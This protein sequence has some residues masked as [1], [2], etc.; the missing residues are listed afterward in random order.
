MLGGCS[1]R[2]SHYTIPNVSNTHSL[3]VSFTRDAQFILRFE[4]KMFLRRI[5]VANRGEIAVRLL[6]TC[7]K[8][9]IE[10]I[11]IYVEEDA[12]ALHVREANE[13]YLLEGSVTRGYLDAAS[14]IRI[15]KERDVQ[16]VLPGYGFL[17]ENAEFA[18]DLQD[19]GI[20]FVGPA[21][22]TLREFGLKDC[23][24]ELAIKVGVP[25]V[26]GTAIIQDVDEA[27]KEAI[28]L[29]FPVS[30]GPNRALS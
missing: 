12:T 22:K 30:F 26:P 8:L 15:C 27:K 7:K 5:L 14:I 10:S 19:A 29:C 23:A 20:H 18:E 28:R 24:R 11:A 17:S 13:A 9:G 1:K 3:T 2:S 21:S 4:N 6:R 25:V 16:A